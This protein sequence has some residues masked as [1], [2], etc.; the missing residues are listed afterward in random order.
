MLSA[1]VWLQIASY[2]GWP[3][4]TTHSIVGA[5]LGFGVMYG[6]INAADW[7]KVGSI[8]ASWVIT[9]PMSDRRYCFLL[10]P[11]RAVWIGEIKENGMA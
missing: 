3:V 6:G 9:I 10:Y 7:A 5:V 4:S 8:A 1:T 2:Y 11:T